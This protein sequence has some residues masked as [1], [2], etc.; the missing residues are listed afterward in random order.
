MRNVPTLPPIA[1]DQGH[2]TKRENT[3]AISVEIKGMVLLDQKFRKV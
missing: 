3:T 2:K 1:S